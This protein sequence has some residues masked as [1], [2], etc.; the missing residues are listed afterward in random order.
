M[1]ELVL[2][3]ELLA[4]SPD[5]QALRAQAAAEV[6]RCQM[7]AGLPADCLASRRGRC[8]AE[9]A[10]PASRDQTISTH[11]LWRET[12]GW[13]GLRL[14][15]EAALELA[16]ANTPALLLRVRTARDAWERFR[17]AWCAAERGPAGGGQ[18]EGKSQAEEECR[19]A[20]TQ[21]RVGRV[22]RL[23]GALRH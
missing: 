16:A 10:G 5:A 4:D 1:L 8:A 20:L 7:S 23:L 2:A 6:R 18:T 22:R 9:L 11:C 15:D 21:D 3:A 13:D 12:E 17:D 14:E 19:N